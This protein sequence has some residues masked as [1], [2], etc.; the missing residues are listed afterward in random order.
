VALNKS[1]GFY[2]AV[3]C[4]AAAMGMHWIYDVEKISAVDANHELLFREPDPSLYSPGGFF[5]KGRRAGQMSHY[6]EAASVVARLAIEDAYTPKAH[7]QKFLESFGPCGS[8]VGYADRPTKALIA[9]LLL[10]GDDLDARSGMDDNQLPGFCAY[11][12]L[13]ATGASPDTIQA[14]VEVVT[15]NDGV[16]EGVSIVTRCLDLLASGSSMQDALQQSIGNESSELTGLLHQAL[17]SP[18]ADSVVVAGEIG[19]ACYVHHALPVTWHLLKHAKDFESVAR[20]NIRCG[21]DSCG[22]AMALGTIA[23]F[24]FGVPDHLLNA[25]TEYPKF[26]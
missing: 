17:D 20:D 1:D 14:A 3:V 13:F 24:Y 19:R 23:G 16:M 21:G 7:Q 25:M 2:G 26:S 12:A 8:F 9:R 4:D 11:P 5:H 10:E 22:R 6:G 18:E 15:I